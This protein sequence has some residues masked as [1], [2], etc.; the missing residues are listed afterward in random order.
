MMV[1]RFADAAC[2]RFDP[3][4]CT[5]SS[6]IPCTGNCVEQLFTSH[7]AP[8]CY[9]QHPANKSIAARLQ[10]KS[11]KLFSSI[12]LGVSVNDECK[13]VHHVPSV[14]YAYNHEEAK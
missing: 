12:P 7:M 4:L 11:S 3:E 10:N 8:P 9:T 5:Q 1:M 14:V 6:A 2:A 13:N